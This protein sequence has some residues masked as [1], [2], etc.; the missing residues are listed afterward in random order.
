MLFLRAQ[1]RMGEDDYYIRDYDS[2][3]GENDGFGSS[4]RAPSRQ[5]RL[6]NDDG[7]D[8]GTHR[9]RGLLRGNVSLQEV[10]RLK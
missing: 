7:N 4:S 3:E 10:W 1:S 2:E 6:G 5:S 8:R 9:S